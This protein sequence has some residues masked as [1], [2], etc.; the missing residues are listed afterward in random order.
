M[1][2]P[3][4]AWTAPVGSYANG[5]PVPT[6]DSHKLNN[7]LVCVSDKFGTSGTFAVGEPNAAKSGKYMVAMNDVDRSDTP[8]TPAVE[9][10]ASPAVPAHSTY[11]YTDRG[12]ISLNGGVFELN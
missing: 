4:L 12:H 5:D 11:T 3:S 7:D 1:A 9:S 2:I 6:T 10:P 8:Y